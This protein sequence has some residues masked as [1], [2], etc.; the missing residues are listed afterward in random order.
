MKNLVLQLQNLVLQKNLVS[1]PGG[2]SCKISQVKQYHPGGTF[3]LLPS[4]RIAPDYLH[5][6]I[7]SK[8]RFCRMP[9]G[10]FFR[11][12]FLN[13]GFFNIEFSMV[14]LLRLIRVRLKAIQ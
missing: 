13:D 1:H 4:D 6:L 10:V 12:S 11:Q 8:T 5:E 3:M 7:S 2:N 14:S 9:I